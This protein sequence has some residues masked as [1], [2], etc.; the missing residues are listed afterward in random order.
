ML[1]SLVPLGREPYGIDQSGATWQSEIPP[2]HVAD[3]TSVPNCMR[4]KT[5][6]F[7]CIYVV[8]HWCYPDLT[9][10]PLYHVFPS[11]NSNPCT[12]GPKC[13]EL[14]KHISVNVECILAN[15]ALLADWHA[16]ARLVTPARE[17]SCTIFVLVFFSSS[18]DVNMSM[19]RQQS[20]HLLSNSI[21]GMRNTQLTIGC[22]VNGR[23]WPA[24]VKLVKFKQAGIILHDSA[25]LSMTLPY[26]LIQVPVRV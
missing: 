10:C 12:V 8:L 23:V 17:I 19:R 1:R 7:L 22:L 15:L 25:R 3:L 21:W 5:H 6:T 4:S 16:A 18:W 11:N 26:T 2:G 14:S 13:A 9:I 20:I 24:D